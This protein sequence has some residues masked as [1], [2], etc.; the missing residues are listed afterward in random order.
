MTFCK[1]TSK[2]EG[3]LATYKKH[4][5]GFEPVPI[6]WKAIMLSR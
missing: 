5:T 3:S 6:A 4:H 1:M 2:N